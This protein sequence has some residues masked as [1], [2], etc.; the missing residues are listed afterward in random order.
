MVRNCVAFAVLL[1]TAASGQ[2]TAPPAAAWPGLFG[3][4]VNDE[5][6]PARL[7]AAGFTLERSGP[8]SL[9]ESERPGAFFVRVEI[10]PMPGN[11]IGMIAASAQFTRPAGVADGP[12]ARAEMMGRCQPARAA[13]V[14]ALF[15]GYFQR[16]NPTS[17]YVAERVQPGQE[18]AAMGARNGQVNCVLDPATGAV[19]LTLQLGR[20]D[21]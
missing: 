20:S 12:A 14:E 11:R 13:L 17:T 19:R 21:F 5:I 1:S 8:L 18:I 6:D 9:W 7:Q 16:S 15:T 3:F 4:A 2:P 10:T